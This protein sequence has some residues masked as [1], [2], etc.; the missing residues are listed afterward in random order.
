[1][2][3]CSVHLRSD[4]LQMLANH[5]VKMLISLHTNHMFQMGKFPISK[6]KLPGAVEPDP[7]VPRRPSQIQRPRSSRRREGRR[8]MERSWAPQ[9][10]MR[11]N[12]TGL[13]SGPLIAC[14]KRRKLGPRKGR[15]RSGSV[16][17]GG[18]AAQGAEGQRRRERWGVDAREHG[19]Q[20]N[21]VSG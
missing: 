13:H 18:A 17:R 4:T 6:V 7:A 9:E 10:E 19:A 15:V 16:G 11:L 12:G 20:R 1:M 5:H 2:D 8:H 3:S 21:G 14:P